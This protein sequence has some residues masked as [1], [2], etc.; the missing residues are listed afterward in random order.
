[1]VLLS[2]ADLPTDQPTDRRFAKSPIETRSQ[3]C[4]AEER[5]GGREGKKKTPA[6]AAGQAKSARADA[7]YDRMSA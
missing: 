1:M 6:A 4:R 7:Q 5:Q 3:N 2:S